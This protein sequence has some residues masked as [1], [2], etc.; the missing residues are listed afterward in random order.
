[1]TDAGFWLVTLL[2]GAGTLAFRYGFLGL[3]GDVELSPRLKRALETL[4][5]AIL[6]ALAMP[7]AIRLGPEGATIDPSTAAGVLAA[8]TLGVVTRN[9]MIALLAG[10][11]AGAGTLLLGAG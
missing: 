6:L 4:P 1:M 5:A 11:A 9:F 7:L 10:L 3:G 8:L 2:I